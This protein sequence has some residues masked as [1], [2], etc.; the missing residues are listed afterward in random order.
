MEDNI[1]VEKDKLLAEAQRLELKGDG[2]REAIAKYEEAYNL[3]AKEASL[4]IACRYLWSSVLPKANKEYAK[5]A[6]EWF[7]IA[8]PYNK[9]QTINGLLI[10]SEKYYNDDLGK[11][12]LQFIINVSKQGDEYA[13]VQFENIKEK[14]K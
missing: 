9:L 11:E 1:T 6:Y 2:D 5:K 13:R 4:R 10:L 3:G 7:Q 8:Y 14:I 12:V